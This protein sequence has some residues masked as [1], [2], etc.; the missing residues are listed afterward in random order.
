MEEILRIKNLTKDYGRIR[1]VDK[2]DLLVEK[3]NIFG[4]LGPNG[5]GKTTTAAVAEVPCPRAACRLPAAHG[6]GYRTTAA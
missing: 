5:S 6:P 2:L 4:I 1:A 3:G